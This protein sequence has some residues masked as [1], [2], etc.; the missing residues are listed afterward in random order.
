MPT[1]SNVKSAVPKNSKKVSQLAM[2]GRSLGN[3]I[4]WKKAGKGRWSRSAVD[5]VP[6][7]CLGGS[8]VTSMSTEATCGCS[9]H[10]DISQSPQTATRLVLLWQKAQYMKFAISS[11]QFTDVKYAHIVTHPSPL[12]IPST[13]PSFPMETLRLLNSNT[14]CPAPVCLHKSGHC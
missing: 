3:G 12:S 1:P 8:R 14:H 13:L 5:A 2:R 6:G 9:A 7:L 11:I 4:P 10:R